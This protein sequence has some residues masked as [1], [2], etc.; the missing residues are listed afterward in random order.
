[1]NEIDYQE[2][3]LKSLVSEYRD[4]GKAK[5]GYKILNKMIA[6]DSMDDIYTLLRS[7]KDS[8]VYWDEL[9]KRFAIDSLIEF[10]NLCFVGA[11]GGI[12]PAWFN[13]D[14]RK[15]MNWILNNKAVKKYYGTNYPYFL[16][17]VTLKH[18][19][20][21]LLLKNGSNTKTTGLF[22]AFLM[23]NSEIKND[24][25]VDCFLNLLDYV[26]YDEF[27]ISDLLKILRTSTS[28]SAALHSKR[29][30]PV[31][32]SVHGFI[33]YSD[34]LNSFKQLIDQAEDF[35]L[36]QSAMWLFHGYY[37]D[38]MGKTITDVFTQGFTEVARN[39]TDNYEEIYE[40]EKRDLPEDKRDAEKQEILHMLEANCSNILILLNSKY[41]KP[42]VNLYRENGNGYNND[43]NYTAGF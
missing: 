10:Y 5:T 27:D 35:P 32:Q 16:T 25:D 9:K 23:L 19:D 28:L 12:L 3:N 6:E 31:N 30:E 2:R 33:K 29:N 8:E 26:N 13:P 39:I 43:N 21:K 41:R 40:V 15:E 22:Y 14:L 42:V 37:F 18:A 38:R 1:M 7:H 36:F 20:A 4:I 11:T 34:F 24:K 17:T